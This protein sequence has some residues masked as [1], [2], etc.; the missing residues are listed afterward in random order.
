MLPNLV[1]DG[2]ML[3]GDSAGF[4]GFTHAIVSGRYAGEVGAEAVQQEDVS[5]LRLKKYQVLCRDIGLHLTIGSWDKLMKLTGLSDEGIETALPEM[6]AR[7][8]VEYRDLL[9]F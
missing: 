3:V 1:K 6:L 9:P 5:E 7:N 4:N 8:E 2:L